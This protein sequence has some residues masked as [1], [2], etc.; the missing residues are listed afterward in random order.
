MYIIAFCTVIIFIFF[1]QS[2]KLLEGRDN[3]LYMLLFPHSI[4]LNL[5]TEGTQ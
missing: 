2:Y 1:L 5:Y 3:D 4:R